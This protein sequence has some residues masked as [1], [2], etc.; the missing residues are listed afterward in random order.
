MVIETAILAAGCF[1]G[2]EAIL[3]GIP[4]V[5]STT[6]GYTGGDLKNPKYRDVKTGETGHTE[7]IR[8]EF[9][10]SVLSYEALLG[11]FFRLHDP[12]QLNRQ[13]GDIGTQ[14]RSAIFYLSETQKTV[15]EKTRAEL[16]A[17]GKWKKPIA[18]QI[19]PA[20]PFWD[21][22]AEHQDYLEKHPDGYTCHWLRD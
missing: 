8:V 17:S 22:E 21:A 1:W 15:A 10:P 4:G 19:V 5:H 11:L 20:L 12:T 9:D 14:Y 3:R 13:M 2:V 16:Q 18:T 6:V 7:A